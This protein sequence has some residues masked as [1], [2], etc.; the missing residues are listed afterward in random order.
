[1]PLSIKVEMTLA[2][3][4]DMQLVIELHIPLAITLHML[5]SVNQG[6]AT[7]SDICVVNDKRLDYTD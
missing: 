7:N 3:N 1:M 2:I 6:Y 4:P 5:I